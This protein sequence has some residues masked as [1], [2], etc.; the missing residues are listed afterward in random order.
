MSVFQINK[1]HFLNFPNKES[2]YQTVC[3]AGAAHPEVNIALDPSTKPQ[4]D[5]PW[6]FRLLQKMNSVANKR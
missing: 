6:D 2:N 3:S 4:W 1:M 5:F